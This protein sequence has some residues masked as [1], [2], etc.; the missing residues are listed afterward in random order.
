MFRSPMR[1]SL[2]S[3]ISLLRLLSLKFT[4]KY[5]GAIV[6]MRKHTSGVPALRSAWSCELVRVSVTSTRK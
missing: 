5:Q 2:G 3:F 1:S 4:K 6:V